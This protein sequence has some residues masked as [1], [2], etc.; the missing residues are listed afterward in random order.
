MR[1]W[2]FTHILDLVF[3]HNYQIKI[4]QLKSK[5]HLVNLKICNHS[6]SYGCIK[7]IRPMLIIPISNTFTLYFLNKILFIY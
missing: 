4:N 5:T 3:F 2:H 6:H 7:F 1:F